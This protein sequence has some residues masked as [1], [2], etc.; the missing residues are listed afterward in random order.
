MINELFPTISLGKGFTFCSLLAKIRKSK[1]VLDKSR[2]T[3]SFEKSINSFHDSEEMY[4]VSVKENSYME[5]DKKE[6]KISLL[7]DVFGRVVIPEENEVCSTESAKLIKIE[8]EKLYSPSS[9]IE[10]KGNEIYKEL[11]KTL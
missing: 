7:E 2:E 6:M 10:S 5:E 3:S 11:G 4:G 8:S 9:T 1:S